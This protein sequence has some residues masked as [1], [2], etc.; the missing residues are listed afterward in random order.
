[1]FPR[2][3]RL[4]IRPQLT[5][6]VVLGT[7]LTTVATLFI[8]DN[9]IRNYV[10]DQAR[11]QQQDNMKIAQLVLTTEYGENISISSPSTACPYGCLVVDIP[12]ASKDVTISSANNY[13]KY[14]LN[15]DTDYVDRVR[16]LVAGSSGGFVS[17]YQCVDASGFPGH[18]NHC[19]AVAD[20]LTSPSN[21]GQR[22]TTISLSTIQSSNGQTVY[23][24]MN[25]QG[26]PR[27]WLG[28]VTVHGSSYYTDYSPLYD[29][30]HKFIGVLAVGVPLDVITTVVSRTTLE[31]IVIGA[32]I[33][34]A[35]VVLS[36]FFAS[37]IVGTLQR[38]ARLVSAS[39]TRMG[40]IAEQQSSGSS[41]QVWA[42][43]AIN[44]ALHNFSEMAQDVSRRTDQL[45]LM[46]DQVVQRRGEISPAQIESIVA[47]ITRS[48]RDISVVSR[49]QAAQYERMTGAMQAVI[50]IAEQVAGN[51]QQASESSERLDLAVRQ[52]QQLV[53]MRTQN[54]GA[55]EPARETSDQKAAGQQPRGTV[56]A[57]RPGKAAAASTPGSTGNLGAQAGRP[58]MG[59]MP[60]MPGGTAQGM[61]GQPAWAPPQGFGI[62]QNHMGEPPAGMSGPRQWQPAGAAP[63]GRVGASMGLPRLNLQPMPHAPAGQE[64]DRGPAQGQ[65]F[66]QWMTGRTSGSRFSNPHQQG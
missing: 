32:I 23:Q 47:Y 62:E 64:G 13:G 55:S 17:V 10:L 3:W 12:G 53:G 40:S 7:I 41:Q 65:P 66:D 58:A 54:K 26:V 59:M 39:S 37:T 6:I 51:A 29:P 21:G 45:A 52:L 50:E 27:E 35:G 14:I 28:I 16:Q 2:W 18:F 36:L 44:Q 56:R 33:M 5:I 42:I 49:Q 57:V 60:P 22:D 46:G 25:V 15:Q 4:G 48:V 61:G 20:T 11:T 24:S 9:A 38:V 1:M 8:A 34:L 63:D 31:L 30:Q 19:P 43:N